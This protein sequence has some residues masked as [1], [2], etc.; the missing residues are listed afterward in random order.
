MHGNDRGDLDVGDAEDFVGLVGLPADLAQ[1][2][3]EQVAAVPEHPVR[4]DGSSSVL[5][6]IDDQDAAGA[7]G[8]VDAPMAV[9]VQR[10][11]GDGD[12]CANRTT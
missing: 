12:A 6:G 4:V 11:G 9:K 3:D 1:G 2:R 10:R 7:D 5:L 8:Q